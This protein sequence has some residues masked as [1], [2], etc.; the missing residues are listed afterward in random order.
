MANISFLVKGESHENRIPMAWVTIEEKDGGALF[1]KVKQLGGVMGNLNGMFF[2]ITDE[3]ILRTLQ[4]KGISVDYCADD[5]S[6][7]LKKYG[8]G[9]TESIEE[10]TSSFRTK[11]VMRQYSFTLQSNARALAL[12]DFSYIQLDYKSQQSNCSENDVND[13]DSHRW[14]YLS[15]Y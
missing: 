7:S 11:E 13:D 10:R 3:T 2:D 9:L 8:T 15:L 6:I 12:T 14:L 4:V 1:F 5:D